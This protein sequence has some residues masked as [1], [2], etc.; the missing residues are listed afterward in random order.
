[1]SS[2]PVIHSTPLLVDSLQFNLF[3][4]K[5][6]EN[7]SL[8]SLVQFVLTPMCICFLFSLL[9]NVSLRKIF[10]NCLR[11]V[12]I[13]TERKR[14]ASSPRD[15]RGISKEYGYTSIHK[16]PYTD[17]SKTNIYTI[18]SNEPCHFKVYSKE[19]NKVNRE[20]PSHVQSTQTHN[21]LIVP[22][23]RIVSTIESLHFVRTQFWGYS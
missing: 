16:T 4:A 9:I 23:F 15:V 2:K 3:S 17:I 6:N 10:K 8:S 12:F 13:K 1:M 20:T 11:Q 18:M 5:Y 14:V 21:Q 7:R 22:N 19:K